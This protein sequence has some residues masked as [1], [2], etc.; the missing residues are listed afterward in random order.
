MQ[1]R[2]ETWPGTLT[3]LC[4]WARNFAVSLSLSTQVYKL[5]PTNLI[6]GGEPSA[7]D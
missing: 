4:S 7:M 3:V 1:S 6:Q 5:V 2:F